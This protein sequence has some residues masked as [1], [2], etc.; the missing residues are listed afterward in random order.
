MKEQRPVV[1]PHAAF[2]FCK[3]SVASIFWLSLIFQNK[4]LVL[5]GFLLLLLSALLK[6]KMAPLVLLYTY[7]IDKIF[8]SKSEILDEKAVC[9]AHMVGTIISGI[10]LLFLY[11]LNPIIGWILTGALAVLKTSASLG[12]CGAMK[13]YSCLN[14]TNG[15]CCRVGKKVKQYKVK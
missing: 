13:L 1:V 10:A 11:F 12:F 6:V 3:Y 14:N 5:V 8:P 2:N 4:L 15:Q 9:F 7:T